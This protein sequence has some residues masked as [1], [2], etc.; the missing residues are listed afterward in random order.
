M[1]NSLL[2]IGEQIYEK[3][4][5]EY[6]VFAK[7]ELNP[8]K[9]LHYILEILFD[10][11]QNKVIISR[12]NL[13]VYSDNSY[14]KYKNLKTLSGNNKKIY[15]T[16]PLKKFED[17]KKSLIKN[18]SPGELY[19]AIESEM[20]E[21]SETQ[22]AK[23]LKQIGELCNELNNIS[24]ATISE[25]LNLA[26]NEELV[27]VSSS[28]ISE[29]LG[30]SQPKPLFELEGY[31][32]FIKRKF[33]TPQETNESLC[34]A[35]GEIKQNV[36][37]PSFYSRYNLNYLF[38]E[39]QI[40]SLTNFQKNKANRNYQLDFYSRLY[41]DIA[42]KY[43][44]ENMRVQIAGLQ[45]VIVPT[46]PDKTEFDF[47]YIE[48]KLSSKIDLIFH[49]HELNEKL[50][51]T[52]E[53]EIE[54]DLFWLN[55]ITFVTE[56]GKAFKIIKQI[57]DVPYFRF[58]KVLEVL[59]LNGKKFSNYLGTTKIFNLNSVYNLIP[60]RKGKDNNI[61]K[62]FLIIQNILENRKI[63]AI[64]LFESFSELIKVHYYN[65]QQ[66][67]SNYIR[68]YGE[69]NLDFAI[70]DTV[71]SYF[72]LFN[73]LLELGLL[74][75]HN[76]NNKTEKKMSEENQKSFGEIIEKFFE[77]MNYSQPQKA[78]F[79]LGRMLNTIAYEQ[80]Q[81][82]HLKK[83][84]LNKLN[85]NGMDKNEILR[86]HSDLFEKARQYGIV[87]KIEFDNGKFTSLFDI[88]SWNLP[89][90]ETLFFILAGYSFGI[91]IA[92]KSNNNEDNNQNNSEE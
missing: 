12:N 17:L 26:N 59:F 35:S 29:T 74:E 51:E 6:I 65:R 23:A 9:E 53:D 84:I 91:A 70:H 54:T 10:C 30:V 1:I 38:V 87:D 27:L 3:F 34:Y 69:N 13:K 72:I 7:P 47:H 52:L 60:I 37:K 79:Y 90:Q 48:P 56:G 31:N 67:Y 66:F 19:Q 44:L 86:L 20:P 39:T 71:Y 49:S 5:A 15:V 45:T 58:N 64:D 28:I 41:L 21:L 24:N 85:F 83:P 50:I 88:N 78:L 80:T 8:K 68:T 43:L 14:A 73:S 16:V 42:S 36:S 18:S 81:K 40:N 32:E 57:K 62:A 92:K 89:P 4:G 46:F 22:F 2:K 61:N 25:K 63:N 33:Y 75:K 76:F 77:E 11:N 82:Q 55:F